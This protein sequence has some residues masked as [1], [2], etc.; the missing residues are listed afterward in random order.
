MGIQ[1]YP[2]GNNFWNK[3]LQKS[4]LAAAEAQ[5]VEG[6]VRKRCTLGEGLAAARGGRGAAR[7]RCSGGVEKR[8][9]AGEWCGCKGRARVQ[10]NHDR[11]SGEDGS[12]FRRRWTPEPERYEAVDLGG[13]EAGF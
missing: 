4:C 10:W 9:G 13:K 7:R 8:D 12:G 6:C 2:P 11:E 1:L 5:Q 3:L